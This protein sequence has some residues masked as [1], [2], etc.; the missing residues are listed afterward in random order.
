MKQGKIAGNWELP[1]ESVC[2]CSGSAARLVAR[3]LDQSTSRRTAGRAGGTR[4]SRRCSMQQ[5]VNTGARDRQ[6]HGFAPA[7]GSRVEGATNLGIE[8]SRVRALGQ[9]GTRGRGRG[10]EADA[11]IRCERK[12]PARPGSASAHGPRV[13]FSFSSY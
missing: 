3:L 9:K 11:N 12:E 7:A 10:R 1:A 2:R 8:D 13:D 4:R 6:R 5:D